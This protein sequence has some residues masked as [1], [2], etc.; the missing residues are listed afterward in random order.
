MTAHGMARPALARTA[1]AY[2]VAVGLAT[3]WALLLPGCA[4]PHPPLAASVSASALEIGTDT[5]G[6]LRRAVCIGLAV[7]TDRKECPGADVDARTVAALLTDRR[8]TVLLDAAATI[9][10]VREAIW[11]AASG[12]GTNDLLTI[13]ISGHGTTRPDA[14]GDEANGKDEGCVL[15]D[16]VWWDDDI[17]A[18]FQT[19]P[20]CR[21]EL[22]SDTCH[23]EGNW[24]VVA[25]ALGITK[26]R[27]VQLELPLGDTRRAEWGGQIIQ[28]AGCR[29]ESYSYGN[30]GGGT[31]T[32][33]LSASYTNGISRARWFS[34]AASRM[35]ANQTPAWSTYNASQ[36]FINGEALR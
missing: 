23:S 9:S 11:I 24:R 18:F 16:G 30:V 20:P 10:G 6:I 17:W 19:L 29:E 31:W 21:I 32:Q 15:Y 28:F 13:S 12:M 33:A 34:A 26:P 4:T 27:Y 22:I 3:G 8:V 14:S 1:M 35:P 36:G 25:E 5:T 7:T 2:A